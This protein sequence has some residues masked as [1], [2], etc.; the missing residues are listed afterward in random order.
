MRF[1]SG[2]PTPADNDEKEPPEQPVSA[3]LIFSWRRSS[4]FSGAAA[5]EFAIQ[6]VGGGK[7]T[8]TR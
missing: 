5:L 2:R 6:R 3:A 7:N 1:A 4:R 8:L